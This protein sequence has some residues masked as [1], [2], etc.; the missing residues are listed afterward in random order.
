M[1]TKKLLNKGKA[2]KTIFSV[3]AS[4]FD[5]M[6]LQLSIQNYVIIESLCFTP[7]ANL[8][9]ITGETG[10]GKSIILGA[11][12]L[13]LGARADVQ[14]FRNPEH[15][16]II[17]AHFDVKNHDVF[18]QLLLEESLDQEPICIIR[19]EITTNGKSRA[20]INDTPVTLNVLQKLTNYL[21]DLHQQFGHLALR[22]DHFQLDVVDA[23]AANHTLLKN[24]RAAYKNYKT[25]KRKLEEAQ[26]QQEKI[27]QEADYKQYLLEELEHAA[28]KKEEIET[29]ETQLKKLANAAQILSILS[30]AKYTLEEGEQPIINELKKISQQLQSIETVL[31]EITPQLKRLLTIY[32][33]LKDVS[34]ELKDIE[35]KISIEPE[36]LEQLQERLDLGYKLFKKHGV[37]T[38]QAILDFQDELSNE[39]LQSHHLSADIQTW[40]KELKLCFDEVVQIANSLSEARQKAIPGIDSKINELLKLVGMPNAQFKIA[41]QSISNPELHGMDQ[42]EFLLDAN[43]SQ[44]FS[45]V[46]K[47]ASG[48]EMSRIMLCIKSL[49]AQAMQMPTLIFDEVDTGISGEAAK[50]VGILLK[51]LAQYHQVICITHQPQVA[52]KSDAHFFVYKE[53][54]NQ[55]ITA[56]MKLLNPEEHIYA[57]AQM[58][59]GEKPSNTAIQNAKELAL[60]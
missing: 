42:L 51:D 7:E 19:R 33:E 20:F 38:T 9:I 23:I 2:K 18:Q 36:M 1:P 25:L 46:Y 35:S 11:L 49:T 47:A 27:Q 28:F 10:A 39:L 4:I 8:N 29:T 48:G 55:S 13:I 53:E 5:L 43:K 60:H 26:A 44:V 30:A 59:D 3:L 6:L 41:L 31:P 15:K 57:I 56:K 14:S 52:A 24:Y 50:Q 45:P 40:E 17:E 12:N 32:E 22:D 21:V 34:Y 58:I 16:C 37:T 54:Q